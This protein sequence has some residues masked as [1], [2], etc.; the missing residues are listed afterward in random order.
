MLIFYNMSR[1]LD[2]EGLTFQYRRGSENVLREVSLVLDAGE[3]LALVGRSGA[4][5]STLIRCL[6]RIIPQF[7]PGN[8]S[9][10]VR[11][12]GKDI[13]G[14]RPFEMADRVGV[15]LQDFES[16]LFSSQSELDVAFGPENLGLDRKEISARVEDSLA[17]VGM[18]DFR[19]RDPSTLSGGQ[20]QRLALATVLALHPRLLALDEVTTDLDPQGR[21][22]V[23]AIIRELRREGI[24]LILVAH[25]PEELRE[26]DRIALLE[27]GTIKKLGGLEEMLG[28]VEGLEGAG[29]RPPDT[30][31]LF[32]EMG[33]PE[34]PLQVE[35]A[36]EILKERGVGFSSE[37]GEG[38]LKRDEQARQ[39]EG[40]V[41]L[42]VRELSHVYPG[43]V[44]AL[45]QVDMEVRDGEFL[46]LVGQNGSGKT[47]LV[48]HLNG[49]LRPTSGEV[50][51]RGKSIHDKSVSELGRD[52]GFVFQNPDHQ[53]FSAR[54]DEEIA[55]GPRNQGL[56]AGEIGDRVSRALDLVG[57]SGC[58]DRDPFIMTK[59]ER[60]RIAVASILA[61]EPGV[62][63]LDEP[64]TGLDYSE[65]VAVMEMLNE[66]NRKGHTIIIITHT[67]WVVARYARR[68]VLMAD[69]MVLEEGPTRDVLSKKDVLRR[70]SL[71]PPEIVE[72]GTALGFPCLTVKEFIEMAGG[73]V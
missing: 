52:I 5:K 59:G 69:G 28:D 14:M 49:L 66:L 55:F 32:S 72:M 65:Q 48:K 71:K 39:R 68:V 47:T 70:A 18:L 33:F 41:I 29:V 22:E 16:Q 24:S 62:V 13:K 38:I 3:A 34:R 9:G 54:V 46:A 4:G 15:V 1:V 56:A 23:G 25:E 31:K 44:K 40:D 43:D 50:L 11:L 35:H 53:I 30:A 2:I 7:F 26:A 51:F 61:M 73:P 45:N 57:L 21:Y 58:E 19:Y 27:H 42:Q 8:F 37:T 67:L 60:Q 63:I 17:R 10:E 12:F 6:N 36:M 64:T 20:K